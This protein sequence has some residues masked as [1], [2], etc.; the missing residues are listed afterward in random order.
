LIRYILTNIQ[1]LACFVTDLPIL[2]TRLVL[3]QTTHRAGNRGHSRAVDRQDIAG[4]VDRQVWQTPHLAIVVD[5]PLITSISYGKLPS[6]IKHPR[7][8]AVINLIY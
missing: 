7:I 1:Q 4:L 3:P 8:Y 2:V 5:P 6:P